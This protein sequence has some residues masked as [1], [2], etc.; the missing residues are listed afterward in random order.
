MS[1]HERVKELG[2]MNDR[3]TNNVRHFPTGLLYREV[4]NTRIIGRKDATVNWLAN[5]LGE[6]EESE[7]QLK[8]EIER[9]G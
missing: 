5:L 8:S 3:D 9:S 7:E 6:F 1:P 2:A 4:G